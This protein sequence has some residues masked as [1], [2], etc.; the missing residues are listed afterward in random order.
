MRV[1]VIDGQGGGIGKQLVRALRESGTDARIVACGTNAEAAR[2]MRKAGA[3]EAF[4]GENAVVREAGLADVVTGPVGIIMS[5][6]IAG[7]ITPAVALAVA[8]ARAVR[9]LVP[10]GKCNTLI[11]GA[12]QGNLASYI[13]DAAKTVAEICAGAAVRAE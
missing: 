8:S 3:D 9:V 10:V 11:A 4:S 6:A 13:R 1:L 5:G 7:E 2:G 12:T